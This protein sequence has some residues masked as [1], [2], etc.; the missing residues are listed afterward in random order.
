MQMKKI[1]NKEI[2]IKKKK[3]WKNKTTDWKKKYKN[4]PTTKGSI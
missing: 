2:I 1:S 4:Q 3:E